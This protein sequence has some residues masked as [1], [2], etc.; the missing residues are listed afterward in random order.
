MLIDEIDANGFNERANANVRVR[1]VGDLNVMNGL[2]TNDDFLN[3]GHEM[4]INGNTNGVPVSAANVGMSAVSAPS[5]R[6]GRDVRRMRYERSCTPQ[7]N[8]PEHRSCE[9]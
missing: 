6:V 7:P 5:V 9:D 8:R 3:N 1:N 4:R 2:G